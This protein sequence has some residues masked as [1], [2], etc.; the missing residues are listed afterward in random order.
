MAPV[1]VHVAAV[2]VEVLMESLE[3]APDGRLDLS[4]VRAK[5]TPMRVAHVTL[6]HFLEVPAQFIEV[7]RRGRVPA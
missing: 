5:E 1:V 2:V 6:K 3:V 7:T 4:E